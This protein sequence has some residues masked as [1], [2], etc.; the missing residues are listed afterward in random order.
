[1][2]FV[3]VCVK[4]I[5]ESRIEKTK[6]VKKVSLAWTKCKYVL[7]FWNKLYISIQNWDQKQM[8][9]IYILKSNIIFRLHN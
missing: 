9:T 5:P 6:T 3:S 7:I 1:M 2:I 4:I 8:Y